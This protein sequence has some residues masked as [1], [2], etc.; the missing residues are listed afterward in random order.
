MTVGND[1]D[2]NRPIFF[3]TRVRR[4]RKAAATRS[5]RR[6]LR[7]VKEIE[8][9]DR[10]SSVDSRVEK[11]YSVRTMT[12]TCPRLAILAA[13]IFFIHTLPAF[14]S[15]QGDAG[16]ALIQTVLQSGLEALQNDRNPAVPTLEEP[17]QAETAAPLPEAKPVK[18][19]LGSLGVAAWKQEA[20]EEMSAYVAK[21]A[22]KATASIVKRLDRDG[23]I[24]AGLQQNMHS[25]RILCWILVIYLFGIS[26][27]M[28]VLLAS[29]RRMR[30]Q[31]AMMNEKLDAVIKKS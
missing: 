18:A 16:R 12:A 6:S 24:R 14:A 9:S 17:P 21:L 15:A 22:D 5:F 13:A 30:K 2:S 10:Y 4:I 29:N 27:F 8:R 3:L 11:A 31:L 20:E 28:F 25:I 1:K 26:P 23:E 19:L 7:N